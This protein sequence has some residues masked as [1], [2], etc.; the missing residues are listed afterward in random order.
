[1]SPPPEESRSPV[2][3][4]FFLLSYGLV[5]VNAARFLVQG[6]PES[7]GAAAWMG[8]VYLT[9]GFLY[10]APAMLLT[11][12]VHLLTSR[13][14]GGR[15]QARLRVPPGSLALGT[16]LVA[17][18]GIQLLLHADIVIHQMYGF[19]I[20]GFVLNILRTPGGV[21]SLG[22][23]SSTQW[24]FVFL[25]LGFLAAEAGLLALALR[26]ERFREWWSRR[27]T[28]RATVAVTV[29]LLL[30]GGLERLAY[31]ASDVWD[32]RPV[33]SAA[34]T[35][36]WYVPVRLRGFAARLGIKAAEGRD[37]PSLTVSARHLKYPKAPVV[38]G[39]AARDLNIVWLV[40]ESWRFD[41]LDPEITPDTWAFAGKSLRFTNHFSAGNGTRMGVFGMFY[42]LYGPYWFP[43]LQERRSP[44]FAD[45]LLDRGYDME[46]YTSARFTFPEFD[47][48]IWARVPVD[49]LHE[50]DPKLSGWQ[51][52]RKFTGEFLESIDRAPKGKPFF[53]FMFFESPHARY[54]F[55]PECVIRTPYLETFNYASGDL[56]K[57][58]PLIFNRYVNSCRHLDT[59]FARVIRGLEE[60]HLLDSTVVLMMGDHG[61]E[62]MERGRW[63]HHSAFNRFQTQTPLVLHYPGVVPGVVNRM[64]SHLDLTATVLGLLGVANPP[65]DYSLGYDLLGPEVRTESVASGWDDLAFRGEKTTVAIPVKRTGIS[66]SIVLDTDDRELPPDQADQ[67]L[68]DSRDRIKAVLSGL[69][70]F[71]K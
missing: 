17:A 60:R 66:H 12:I 18:S 3:G 7:F 29:L 55:P 30:L 36:P 34:E 52:D 20:N 8:G 59:Q 71:R 1:M 28:P 62:F 47:K 21:E 14:P 26:W 63:G 27:A 45:Y 64:T 57:Q 9:Y 25:A 65:S 70:R 42:G 56:E 40:S 48:T 37:L 69:S 68:K 32:Y 23:D 67:V 53:R 38:A 33:L 10:L 54:Y 58:M 39:P 43:F 6:R 16:A 13:G 46:C 44:V 19:H 31:A 61:E 35:F 15:L 41:M 11:W 50:G 4:R 24:T 49:R 22:A 51:N 5:L 2:L